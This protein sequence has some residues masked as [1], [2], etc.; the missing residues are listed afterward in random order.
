MVKKNNT[1]KTNPHK[2][3][4]G[5]YAPMPPSY[6]GKIPGMNLPNSDAGQNLGDSNGLTIRKFLPEINGIPNTR[7]GFN[8]SIMEPFARSAAQYA[9]PI[10]LYSGYRLLSHLKKSKK[11]KKNTKKSKKLKK[12]KNTTKNSS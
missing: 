2:Q 6:L 10:A 8:P 4:G 9:V 11:S 5:Y 1:R 3:Y 12:S 7:G